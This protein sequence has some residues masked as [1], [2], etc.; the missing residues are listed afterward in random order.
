MLLSLIYF[1]ENHNIIQ[2]SNVHLYV[3]LHVAEPGQVLDY[4]GQ[5]DSRPAE[6]K[7]VDSL[8]EDLRLEEPDQELLV[9]TWNLDVGF[10]LVLTVF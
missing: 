7:V 1:N 8:T 9:E 10:Q 3:Y 6:P 5:T 4:L 2:H